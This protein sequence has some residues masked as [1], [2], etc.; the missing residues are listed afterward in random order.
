M[1]RSGG[2]GFGG[3]GFSGGFSGGGRMS[4][5]FSGGLGFGGGRSGGP[6]MGGSGYSGGPIFVGGSG[7]G[8]NGFL[9]GL[10]LGQ[11]LSESRGGSNQ[12][13][14]PN[15]QPVDPQGSRPVQGPSAG[16]SCLVAALVMI[17]AAIFAMALF[18]IMGT[19]GC[20]S[21][22]SGGSEHASTIERT[23]LASGVVIETPYYTD[24]DGDWIG[25]PK[26][27]E[28]GMREFYMETGVQPYLHILPNGS[29]RTVNA[30]TT[31]AEDE[32]DRLFQDEGHF[33]VVFCDNDHGG[34]GVGY[35]IG[36]AVKT[37]MD[38]EAITIFQDYLDRY[39]S[40][41]T[42]S[43]SEMFADTYTSTADRIMTTDAERNKPI[44]IALIV[45][46]VIVIV[47]A[48]IIVIVRRR[49]KTREAELRHQEEVLNIPLEKFGDD[50]VEET[51]RKYAQGRATVEGDP[52]SGAVNATD[53]RDYE[54][55]G[56]DD[57]EDLERKYSSNNTA[58]S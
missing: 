27:L 34:F 33:L 19:G 26:T 8:G 20:S 37:V 29:E 1:G 28:T 49:A 35:S 53:P 11:L 9:G 55:F 17:A 30:L 45:G 51:A 31:I 58:G 38:S 10:I 15:G 44:I 43:E 24:D 22:L 21:N 46:V 54:K 52:N 23:P 41:Y 42:I 50:E 40:D 5:G 32:Y 39:Y 6:S 13:P 48:G 25:D 7:F 2:G 36:S 12:A 4:G 3:G 14:P 57:L 47:V 18:M 56:D 16:G